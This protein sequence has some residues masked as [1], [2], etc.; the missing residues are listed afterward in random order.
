MVSLIQIHSKSSIFYKQQLKE[1]FS[2]FY[3][4]QL[5]NNYTFILINIINDTSFQGYALITK[6]IFYIF[7]KVRFE[8]YYKVLEF[9]IKMNT[10]SV[11]FYKTPLTK[12][13][14]LLTYFDHTFL[15]IYTCKYYHMRSCLICFYEYF[16]NTIKFL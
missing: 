12:C 3:K 11:P 1:N 4:Q 15:V 13:T 8:I 16:Q 2:H 9:L 5:I 6:H 10:P 14:I 7:T